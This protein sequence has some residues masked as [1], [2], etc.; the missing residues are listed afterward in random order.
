MLRLNTSIPAT[1][2]ALQN[3]LGVIAGYEKGVLDASKADLSG[4]PNGRRLGDDVVDIALRVVMGKLL[5]PADAPVGDAPLTDGAYVD[6]RMFQNQF[7]YVN[8]P[9]KG[10]PNDPSFTFVPKTAATVNGLYNLSPA[11]YDPATRTLTVP[12]T[13]NQGFLLLESAGKVKL[14]NPVLTGSSLSTVLE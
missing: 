4:F 9:L 7:P 1:P 12:V 8:P 14:T 2:R 3:N 5:K 6:A 10:S 11:S 13:D